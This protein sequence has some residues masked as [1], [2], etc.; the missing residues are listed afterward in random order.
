MLLDNE[1]VKNEIKEEIRKF[2]ETKD[3]E[4]T[5]V[6][7]LWDTVK[8]VLREKFIALQAY[9]KKKIE[10]SQ[11]HNLTL[12]IQELEEQQQRQPRATTRKKI[13]KIRAD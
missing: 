12:H 11:I 10:T 7:N 5:T 1:W 2:L 6:L 4:L 3:N 13:T 8:A 9:L